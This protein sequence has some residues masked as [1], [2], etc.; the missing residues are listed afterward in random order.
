MIGQSPAGGVEP[1]ALHIAPFEPLVTTVDK[2][3]CEPSRFCRGPLD[4]G[5]NEQERKVDRIVN[6]ST[7]AGR[8]HPNVVVGARAREAK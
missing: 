7:S 6:A 1:S 3:G 5:E 2:Q 8:H 4:L